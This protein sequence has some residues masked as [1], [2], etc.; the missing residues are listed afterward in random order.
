MEHP[1]KVYNRRKIL[2]KKAME[3]QAGAPLQGPYYFVY[4]KPNW[5]LKAMPSKDQFMA[6]TDFWPA[7]VDTV[8]AP[9]YKI[10]DPRR[11]ELLRGLVYS[12]PRG[13]VSDYQMPRGPKTWIVVCGNDF[14]MNPAEQK[15]VLSQFNLL[16]QFSAGLVKFKPDDHEVMFPDEFEDFKNLVTQIDEKSH[17]RIL[18]PDFANDPAYADDE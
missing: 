9:F 13:R 16:Q 4:L 14:T 18:L 8:I 1:A 17:S 7:L 11:L 6:H 5:V 10:K 12:M 2:A 15:Q 3:K